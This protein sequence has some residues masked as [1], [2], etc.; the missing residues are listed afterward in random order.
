MGSWQQVTVVG[1]QLLGAAFVTALTAMLSHDEMLAYGWRIPFLVGV[2]VAGL[3]LYIR[4]RVDD[5]PEFIAAQKADASSPSSPQA[6]MASALPNMFR[7]VG[8]TALWST[9][10]AFTLTYIPSFLK[11]AGFSLSNGLAFATFAN[12]LVATLIPFAGL[13][14][15]K[16]PRPRLVAIAAILTAVLACPAT[17]IM[18]SGS[19]AGVFASIVVFAGIIAI[20]SGSGPALLAELFPVRI[21]YGALSISYAIAAACF[22]GFGPFIMALL[23]QKTGSQISIAYYII[24]AGLVGLLA[25]AT[26]PKGN[27]N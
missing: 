23:V 14:A 19:V 16:Y 18:S 1:G 2:L 24:A 3:G 10:F 5:T 11:Q 13:L 4:T 9:N 7:V 6:S 27:S 15:D 21:R 17:A 26:I 22:A 12:I 8:I 25:A 20:I